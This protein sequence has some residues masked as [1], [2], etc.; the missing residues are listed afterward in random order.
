[1]NKTSEGGK[2][3]ILEDLALSEDTCDSRRL[4]DA[5]KYAQISMAGQHY[6][7]LVLTLYLGA[8]LTYGARHPPASRHRPNCIYYICMYCM[9]VCV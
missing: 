3:G 8:P 9:Y 7:C 6:V 1:M 2:V 5:N 4:K